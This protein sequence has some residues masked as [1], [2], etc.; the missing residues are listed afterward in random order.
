MFQSFELESRWVARALSGRAE[1]PGEEA[2][3]AAVEEDYR[4]MDAAGKPKR[5]THALMPDWVEYMDWVAAQVGEPPMEA[6]RREIYE[7]ALRCIWS[8]DDSY[9]DSWEEEE[10]EEN[11]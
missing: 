8:L 1:L 4:R 11:R 6:R 9:R 7:K 3:A 2:M 10:E 5:H